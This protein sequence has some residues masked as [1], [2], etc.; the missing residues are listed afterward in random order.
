MLFRIDIVQLSSEAKPSG[1]SIENGTTLYFVDTRQFFIL[2]K[3]T[4]YEQTLES[5]A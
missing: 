4:W 3:G 1:D 5:E 2:Y